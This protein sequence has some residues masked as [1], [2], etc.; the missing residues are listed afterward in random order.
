M[1]WLLIEETAEGTKKVSGLSEGN[2]RAFQ[3]PGTLLIL[4]A[5]AHVWRRFRLHLPDLARAGLVITFV[6][7]TLTLVG[8]IV[9]FGIWGEGPLDGQDP[10][11]AIFFSGLYVLLLG[12]ILLLAS[13]VYAL[14]RHDGRDG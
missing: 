4:V 7:L 5:I 14:G 6:A 1:T 10:G 11:A 2:L 9:E 3:N 12:L 13:G 8:N